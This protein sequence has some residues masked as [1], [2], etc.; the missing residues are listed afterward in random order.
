MDFEDLGRRRADVYRLILALL[1]VTTMG[2]LSNRVRQELSSQFPLH[3]LSDRAQD[4]HAHFVMRLVC[5]GAPDLASAFCKCEA[6]IMEVRLRDMSPEWQG[7]YVH[8]WVAAGRPVHRAPASEV[9]VDPFFWQ[10]GPTRTTS[11]VAEHEHEHGN[12]TSSISSSSSSSS[13]ASSSTAALSATG[14]S[15]VAEF[16]EV[17]MEA[18]PMLVRQRR[19]VVRNGNMRVPTTTV[20]FSVNGAGQTDQGTAAFG[21]LKSAVASLLVRAMEISERARALF[22]TNPATAAL[23]PAVARLE[24]RVRAP[25]TTG[26]TRVQA[27]GRWLWTTSRGIG[28]AAEASGG[29]GGDKGDTGSGDSGGSGG[30]GGSGSTSGRPSTAAAAATTASGSSPEDEVAAALSS[31]E[32]LQM[33]LNL[34]RNPMLWRC[35]PPCMFRLVDHLDLTHHLKFDGR[36]QLMVFFRSIGLPLADALQFL[37]QEFARDNT[38]TQQRYTRK[39]YE[40]F[41]RHVYGREGRGVAWAAQKCNRIQGKRG[42]GGAGLGAGGNSSSNCSSGGGGGGSNCGSGVVVV[43]SGALATGIAALRRRPGDKS[44]AAQVLRQRL[45]QQPVHGCPFVSLSAAA[46]DGMLDILHA[47]LGTSNSGVSSSKR[48]GGGVGANKKDDDDDGDSD[49]GDDDQDTTD[50]SDGSAPGAPSTI[51]AA[52]RAGAATSR[53]S[54]NNHCGDAARAATLLRLARRSPNLAC[55]FH[56]ALN[57]DL[58]QKGAAGDSNGGGDDDGT[59]GFERHSQAIQDAGIGRTPASYFR[60]ATAILRA[61]QRQQ[62]QRDSGGGGGGGGGRGGGDG[63]SRGC[64]VAAHVDDDDN[65]DDDDHDHDDHDHDDHDH[66][67]RDDGQGADEVEVVD[68]SLTAVS[69]AQRRRGP[70][71]ADGATTAP[72]RPPRKQARPSPGGAHITIDF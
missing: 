68:K 61:R 35:F 49:D 10:Q 31:E 20:L 56:F 8:K 11:S 12:S 36:V 48:R 27:G 38:M 32:V 4:R 67:D 13:M 42:G 7:Q 21:V 52:G 17:P 3:T 29:S 59:G 72:A 39:R 19:V 50:E 63:C 45:G 70:K 64:D 66:D 28:T 34:L 24:V 62:A 16:W 46:A 54:G 58:L 40:Y 41:V 55:Q 47:Q 30:S 1:D 53:G 43:S 60:G 37:R 25:Y 33:D 71:Q 51:S 18:C 6:L 65:D 5:G 23:A 2:V 44:A 69:G 22:D 9:L 15:S 26:S 57:L 14:S